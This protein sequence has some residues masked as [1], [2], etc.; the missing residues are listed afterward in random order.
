MSPLFTYI[1]D[2]ETLDENFHALL[3]KKKLNIKGEK[4]FLFFSEKC[5]PSWSNQ[6]NFRNIAARVINNFAVI[7]VSDV[8]SMNFDVTTWK[9]FFISFRL[10]PFNLIRVESTYIS[11][12]NTGISFK[13]GFEA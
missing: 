13:T 10:S 2:S 8:V 11:F 9:K 7:L 1:L 6:I 5:I 12:A 3:L 4:L